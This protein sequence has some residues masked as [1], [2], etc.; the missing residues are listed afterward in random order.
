MRDPIFVN[1]SAWIDGAARVNA[2]SGYRRPRAGTLA[3]HRTPTPRSPEAV[4]V[5][6]LGHARSIGWPE[7]EGEDA[8]PAGL[9]D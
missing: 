6:L 1:V 8:G 2:R 9:P 3:C 4:D 7:I 5:V